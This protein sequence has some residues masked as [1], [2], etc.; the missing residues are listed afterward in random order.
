MKIT[1]N[2]KIVDSKP[3]YNESTEEVK[4]PDGKVRRV[5]KFEAEY[6]KKKLAN[7]DKLKKMF[8]KPKK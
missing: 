5:N 7:S 4:F 1:K 6:L 3:F 2:G 8:S